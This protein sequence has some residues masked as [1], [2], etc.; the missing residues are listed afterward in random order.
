[1]TFA[2]RVKNLRKNNKMTQDELAKKSGLGLGQISKIERGDNKEPQLTTIKKLID[3]L[4]ITADKLIPSKND[5][6][7]RGIIKS[8]IET[9][10]NLPARD[11]DMVIRLIENLNFEKQ[12]KKAMNSADKAIEKHEADLYYEA[13]DERREEESMVYEYE[14]M[15]EQN[16]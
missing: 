3:G 12:V 2:E 8:A 6:G 16:D 1:M 14:K 10:D 13:M 9:V 15:K 4:E 7:L 11:I 5:K